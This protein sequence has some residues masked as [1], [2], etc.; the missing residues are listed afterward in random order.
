MP[1]FMR[2]FLSGIS[3]SGEISYYI[4]KKTPVNKRG[5]SILIFYASTFGNLANAFSNSSSVGI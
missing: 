4:K 1:A 3:P 5:F 2:A